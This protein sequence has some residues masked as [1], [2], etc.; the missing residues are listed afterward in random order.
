V[1]AGPD[2]DPDF[3]RALEQRNEPT[4]MATELIVEARKKP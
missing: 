4:E 2:D 1:P 3:L